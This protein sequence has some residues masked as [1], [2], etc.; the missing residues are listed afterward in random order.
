MPCKLMRDGV[1]ERERQPRNRVSVVD[2]NPESLWTMPQMMVDAAATRLSLSTT[3][4]HPVAKIRYTYGSPTATARLTAMLTAR[5]PAQHKA[6]P[7]R[8]AR[9]A[10]PA[11]AGTSMPASPL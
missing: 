1:R 9:P 6:Q 7:P 10:R 2:M 8:P 5:L 3:S 11:R 4:I